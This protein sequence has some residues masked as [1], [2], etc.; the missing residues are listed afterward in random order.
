ME[1]ISDPD[2]DAHYA[3]VAVTQAS[4]V[5]VVWQQGTALIYRKRFTGGETWD[6][7]V[8]LVR[9]DGGLGEPALAGEPTGE[10]NLAWTGWTSVSERDL[11]LSQR[12]PL[13]RPKV[14]MPGIVTGR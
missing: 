13:L 3:T 12:E 1:D 4:Q 14:F 9:N 2:H 6:P 8:T 10:I 11:F 5:S 7:Q